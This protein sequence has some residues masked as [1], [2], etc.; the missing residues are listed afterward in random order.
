MAAAQI[1]IVEDEPV[2]AQAIRINLENLGYCVPGIFSAGEDALEYI[3][4]APPDLVIMDVGLQGKLDGVQTAERIHST[5]DIPIIFTTAH[6]DPQTIKRAISTAPFGYIVKPFQTRELHMHIEMALQ[7]RAMERKIHESEER[8]RK[9]TELSPFAILL[10]RMDGNIELGNPSACDL[11]GAAKPSELVGRSVDDLIPVSELTRFHSI[12]AYPLLERDSLRH[13]ESRAARLDGRTFPVEVSASLMKDDQGKPA[14]IIA[15][16]QD[17]SEK[18]AAEQFILGQASRANT[19]ARVAFEVNRTLELDQVLKTVREEVTATLGTPGVTITLIDEETGQVTVAAGALEGS[20]NAALT[21]FPAEF[22]QQLWRTNGPVV[23]ILDLTDYDETLRGQ[24]L[25]RNV[26]S[27][28]IAFLVN[29]GKLIGSIIIPA[30][31]IPKQLNESDLSLLAAIADLASITISHARLFQQVAEGRRHLQSL[32]RQLVEVQEAERRYLAHELHD[33]IGQMLTG[34]Q[35]SLEIGKTL[36]EQEVKRTIAASQEAVKEIIAQVR[37][38]SLS[39]RPS[40]LD[41]MGLLPCLEWHFERY[42]RQTGIRVQ[43]DHHGLEE[44]R[45][46]QEIEITIFRIIQ[47]ALTNIA[48]HTEAPDAYVVAQAEED[49]I[50]ITIQDQ[51]QGFDVQAVKVEYESVGLNGM[52]ERANLVGGQ[53]VIYS[54]PG[55]GTQIQ[56]HIPTHNRL[57]RRKNGRNR[58]A[59]R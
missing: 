14:R 13:V 10:L 26:K 59:R 11:F 34:L 55:R 28:V 23:Q 45:F 43:F 33:Q 57:E 54:A 8:Y 12:L 32:S 24:P 37:E 53:L 38:L 19:L 41:D 5:N 27:V 46:L 52:R 39:L 31:D 22:L 17:I 44:R 36:P 20:A 4:S 16:I 1:V 35:F 2:L 25:L 29:S 3:P 51:G 6:S 47:E 9:L 49:E 7:I 15:V 58:A 48:R 50:L 56:A 42:T 18:K 30:I 21:P 40:L